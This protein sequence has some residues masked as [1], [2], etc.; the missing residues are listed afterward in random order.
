MR[1]IAVRKLSIHGNTNSSTRFR[2]DR[3]SSDWSVWAVV[4]ATW[5]NA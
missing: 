2:I 3:F 1:A 5:W 4:T